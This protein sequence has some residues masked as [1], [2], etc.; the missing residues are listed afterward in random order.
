M[1]LSGFGMAVECEK[2]EASEEVKRG[3]VRK[4]GLAKLGAKTA[5]EVLVPIR[6]SVW[7]ISGEA[8]G[9]LVGCIINRRK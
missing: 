9:V 8:M 5:P 7:R 6:E 3:E 1:L 2:E 4:D